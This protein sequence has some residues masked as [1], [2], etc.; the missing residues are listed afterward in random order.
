M[1]QK[2]NFNS[3]LQKNSNFDSKY[4]SSLE[5]HFPPPPVGG[6]G[7]VKGSNADESP[8]I[9]SE[10]HQNLHQAASMT[11]NTLV[12]YQGRLHRQYKD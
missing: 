11:Q 10:V 4:S 6:T 12:T 5:F 7:S 1:L 3:P 8:K 9:N 2:A